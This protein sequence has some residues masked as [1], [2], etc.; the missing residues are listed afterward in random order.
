MN[1]TALWYASQ[2]TGVVSLLMF[3]LVMLLGAA[4]AGQGRLPGLPRFG[5]VALHRSISLLAL[6]FL[7][8]HIGT[9]VLDS[10]VH[11][12][13]VSV[14]VPFASAYQP[15][16]I[17]LGAVAIDLM[18]ALTISSLLRARIDPRLWRAVHWTAYACW[19]LAIAHTIALGAGRGTAQDGW[20]LW[21]TLGCVAAVAAGAAWRFAAGRARARR[22]PAQVFH[23]TRNGAFPTTRSGAKV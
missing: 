9:A 5:V 14:F 23:T 1:A 17:G 12:S 16:W 19:P 6:A 4:V 18:L 15:L 3:T 10:Y 21:L 2:A 7:A 8:V 11:I 20:G 22:T 13:V